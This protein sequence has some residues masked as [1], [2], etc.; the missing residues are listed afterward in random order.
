VVGDRMGMVV[1]LMGRDVGIPVQNA[2]RA[3]MRK[4][5]AARMVR[6]R[7]HRSSCTPESQARSRRWLASI[8][9]PW[10]GGRW[11]SIE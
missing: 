10:T 1:F 2:A 5:S 7:F 6:S 8:S 4:P 9:G 11:W 3:E